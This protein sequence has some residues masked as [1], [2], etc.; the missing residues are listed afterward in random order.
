M[1]H[2]DIIR[3]WK[4]SDYRASLDNDQL[5]ALPSH[6]A[7]MIEL[8]DEHLTD[9]AGGAARPTH[10]FGSLGCAC[11]TLDGGTCKVA[12]LGCCDSRLPAD[13]VGIG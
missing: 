2:E 3:A 12:T 4:D 11:N 9:V 1:S 7:G 6:P 13:P 8:S 5:N 10:K